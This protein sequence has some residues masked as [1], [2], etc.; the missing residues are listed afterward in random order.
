MQLKS[1][2]E[3][4]VGTLEVEFKT[5]EAKAETRVETL[6]GEVMTLEGDFNTFEAKAE[7]RVETLQGE[8]T[9][10]QGR[11]KFFD[12]EMKLKAEAETRVT[13]FEREVK[14]LNLEAVGL[15]F[16]YKQAEKEKE[17]LQMILHRLLQR[18]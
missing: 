13:A 6:Q 16:K 9:T 3:T 17:L 1:E 5:F 11:V 10:L 14:T 8:A 7:T 4:C 15:Q 12:A 18:S 2:A